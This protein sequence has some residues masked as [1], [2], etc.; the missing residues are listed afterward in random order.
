M[1]KVRGI[2][3]R[4]GKFAEDVHHRLTRSRG[5]DVLDREG[6]TYHLINLC[7]NHHMWVHANISEATRSG[8]YLLGQVFIDGGR[9]LYLGP[10]QYLSQRYGRSLSA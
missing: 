8:L 3:T 5:G 9:V 4:C 7:H 2:Y 10:D 6:E 1:V